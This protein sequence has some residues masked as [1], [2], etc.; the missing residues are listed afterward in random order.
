MVR[1]NKGNADVP[2]THSKKMAA[3]GLA[4]ALCLGGYALAPSAAMASETTPSEQ[5]QIAAIGQPTFHAQRVN[6]GVQVTLEN[7]KFVSN[8]DGSVAITSMTGQKLDSLSTEFEGRGIS[9][10]VLSDSKLMAYAI[11][12]YSAGSYANCIAHTALGGGVTG[13]ISGAIAGGGILGASLGAIG[14]IVG[15][16]VWGLST[17]GGGSRHEDIACSL[18]SHGC[19]DTGVRDASYSHRIHNVRQLNF[20]HRKGDSWNNH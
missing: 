20:A 15:G 8:S 2:V 11:V 18:V 17:A 13:A 10:Q 1:E 16:M 19:S 4:L 3:L 9:Y 14:G 6:G 7:A 5:T 12:T